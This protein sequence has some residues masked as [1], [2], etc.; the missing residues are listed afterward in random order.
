VPAGPVHTIGQALEHP[1]VRARD[2]V[3]ALEHPRAGTTQALGCPIKLSE[4]PAAV[5]RPAPLLGQHTRQV[6]E[7]HG[8]AASEI[9]ELVAA[10]VVAES[11]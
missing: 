8:F 10:G 2:M 9:D 11:A 3:V 5:Q 7:E 6:L 1:Q 4:T